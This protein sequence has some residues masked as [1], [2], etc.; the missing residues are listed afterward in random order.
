MTGFARVTLGQAVTT[1]AGTVRTLVMSTP[2]GKAAGIVRDYVLHLYYIVDDVPRLHRLWMTPLLLGVEYLVYRVDALAER[3]VTVDLEVERNRDYD[4]FHA[5]KRVFERVLRAIGAWND[6]VARRIEE[7]ECFIRMENGATSRGDVG[8][9]D[10]MALVELRPTDVRLLH[11]MTSAL[12]HRPADPAVR[13][14]L[15]PV[16]V[17]ADIANDLQ[18]YGRDVRTGALNVYAAFVRLH[19]D[20]AAV[21]LRR[22]VDRYDATVRESLSRVPA[23]RRAAVARACRRRYA[24]ALAPYPCPITPPPPPPPSS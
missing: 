10:V 6:D 2:L 15:W 22:E 13:D 23:D 20:A 17:L 4:A 12:R 19:G 11:A 3:N 5:Y 14:L 8:R 18:H 21:E 24:A 16:E 9:D 7:G 1:A